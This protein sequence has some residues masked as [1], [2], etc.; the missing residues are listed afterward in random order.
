VVYSCSR[1]GRNASSAEK[2]IIVSGKKTLIAICAASALGSVGVAS[3]AQAGGQSEDRGGFVMPGSMD[4]VNPV[5]H[6]EWFGKG[7]NAGN[8]APAGN[9]FGYAVPPVRKH[10]PA[11][12]RTQDR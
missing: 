7:A 6:P 11:H 9:A 12:E 4:G 1:R 10:R 2:E 8:A 5:Y 3:V